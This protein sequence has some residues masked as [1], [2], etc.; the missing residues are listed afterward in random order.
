MAGPNAPSLK[1]TVRFWWI[2]NGEKAG[3]VFVLAMI[4]SLC[5]LVLLARPHYDPLIH[6]GVVAGFGSS[7]TDTGTEMYA[8]VYVDRRTTTV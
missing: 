6:T 3:L 2:R 8:R 1:E 5:F 7:S 4:A